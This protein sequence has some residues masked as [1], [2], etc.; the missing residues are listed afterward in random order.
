[1]ATKFGCVVKYNEEFSLTKLHDPL[2]MWFCEV[3][4]QIQDCISPLAHN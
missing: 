4:S 2:I 3:T 1:M